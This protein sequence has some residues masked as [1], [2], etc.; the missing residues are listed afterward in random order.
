[1]LDPQSPAVPRCRQ[2]AV[3]STPFRASSGPLSRNLLSYSQNN[4]RFVQ[5][6]TQDTCRTI[7]GIDGSNCPSFRDFFRCQ[8]SHSL[9]Y[10]K[11]RRGGHWVSLD[12]TATAKRPHRETA[13][14][15][16]HPCNKN[17]TRRHPSRHFLS[18]LFSPPP[19][20]CLF[21]RDAI[22]QFREVKINKRLQ[23]LSWKL[24]TTAL[25]P[26]HT[27]ARLPYVTCSQDLIA[28][29]SPSATTWTVSTIESSPSSVIHHGCCYS[30]TLCSPRWGSSSDSDEHEE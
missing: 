21:W 15:P 28:I 9:H 12:E 8:L 5:H 1:M 14:P 10:Q 29:E 27:A 16:R 3:S 2:L 24:D 19:V 4:W 7:A 20:N 11:V 30:T 22:P 18:P 6:L 26:Q 23:S 25:E 13:R 17:T